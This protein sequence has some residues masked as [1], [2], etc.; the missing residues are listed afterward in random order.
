VLNGK[1]NLHAALRHNDLRYC[2]AGHDAPL[3]SQ[4][5]IS[6]LGNLLGLGAWTRADTSRLDD[7]QTD[8]IQPD[9]VAVS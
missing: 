6:L 4:I 9:E 5:R 7:G 8:A 3:V 1:L 2:P